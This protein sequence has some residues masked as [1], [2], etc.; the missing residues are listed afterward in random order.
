MA[1]GG[2]CKCGL[3]STSSQFESRVGRADSDTNNENYYTD[4]LQ[5]INTFTG[6]YKKKMPPI[7]SIKNG[8]D[9][10]KILRMVTSVFN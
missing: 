10:M 7:N 5:N 6:Y 8:F 4:V 9:F 2:V 1:T 3:I